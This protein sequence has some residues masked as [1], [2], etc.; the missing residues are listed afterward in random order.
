MIEKGEAMPLQRLWPFLVCG[1]RTDNVSN[2]RLCGRSLSILETQNLF[3]QTCESSYSPLM[4]SIFFNIEPP[5]GHFFHFLSFTVQCSRPQVGE[6][7]FQL[8]SM[9]DKWMS[10]FLYDWLALWGVTYG[11]NSCM[12]KQEFLFLL[13]LYNRNFLSDDHYI[14]R[15]S[16]IQDASRRACSDAKQCVWSIHPRGR[17]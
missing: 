17:F 9:N 6:P 3:K 15:K 2:K 1:T 5:T 13:K 14:L 16:W 10:V 4:L 12:M 7:M 11:R 8:W